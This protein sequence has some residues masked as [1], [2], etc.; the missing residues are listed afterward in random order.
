MQKYVLKH[1]SIKLGTNEHIHS[2]SDPSKPTVLELDDVEAYKMG[3]DG[4]LQLLSDYEA[5]LAGA[6]PK[7][8]GPLGADQ[9]SADRARSH[10]GA[11]AANSVA[12]APATA[13]THP[14]HSKPK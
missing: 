8:A 2:S 7:P 10:R 9:H 3:G 11:G 14:H 13:S 1:G 4:S 5:E 12:V 6:A